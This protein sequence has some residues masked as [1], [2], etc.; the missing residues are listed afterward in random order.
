MH[1]G[2]NLKQ[3][4][5]KHNL[6]QEE[7]AEHLGISTQTVSKWERGLIMPDVRHLP[8]LAVLYHTSIDS[9]FNMQSYWDNEHRKQ[10]L[11]TVQ[12]LNQK[13]NKEGVF[14]AWISEIELQ[15]DRFSDYI[16]V[17]VY[18]FQNG[19][20]EDAHIN[21]LLQLTEYA[22]RNCPKDDIRNEIYRTMLQITS[23]AKN[24]QLRQKAKVF[25]AFIVRERTHSQGRFPE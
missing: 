14:W 9:I 7:V 20:F 13:G 11:N 12:L 17:M 15:P 2:E 24:P 16:T 8:A 19:L 4:R 18:A 10:F 5:H 3:L 6:T 23:Y 25:Y 21:R 1:I 22:R